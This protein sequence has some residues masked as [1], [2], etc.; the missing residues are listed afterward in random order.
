V[1]DPLNGS[2]TNSYSLPDTPIQ[3][4]PLPLYDHS[5]RQLLAFILH[6]ADSS[7]RTSAFLY[8]DNPE[9]HQLLSNSTTPIY[10]YL[11]EKESG[12]VAGYTLSS[13]TTPTSTLA[14]QVLLGFPIVSLAF[15]HPREHIHSPAAVLGDRSLLVKYLN[16]NI[17][18]LAT[19]TSTST[20]HIH[21][22]DTITGNTIFYAHHADASSPVSLALTENTV[23][24]TYFSTKSARWTLSVVDLFEKGT[25]WKGIGSLGSSEVERGF[26]SYTAPPPAFNYHQSYFL[27]SGVRSLTTTVSLNGI[28]SRDLILSLASGQ[29]VALD[30]KWINP[31]R[32]QTTNPTQAEK[33]EG[34]VPYKPSLLFSPHSFLSYNRI[35]PRLR[36][37]YTDSTYLESTSLILS[38]GID[39]FWTRVAPSETYDLLNPDFNYFALALTCGVLFVIT[40]LSS[41]LAKKKDLARM[42]K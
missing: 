8:P 6:V 16:K 20:L 1:L 4:I 34:L 13:P 27:P 40:F 15:R 30:V 7:D 26:S 21:V 10:Y 5:H 2:I 38:V 28:T 19:I 17:I 12:T 9:S 31:R 33:D 24:C 36:S 32:P 42:W 18:A 29:V 11:I 14:W 39:I 37:S 22:L 3:T 35:I 23:V 25:E 41:R